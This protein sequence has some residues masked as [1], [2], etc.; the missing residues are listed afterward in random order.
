MCGCS[1]GMVRGVTFRPGYCSRK[2]GIYW[3]V[4]NMVLDRLC[5]W[6]GYEL[7][8]MQVAVGLVVIVTEGLLGSVLPKVATS[9]IVDE[10]KN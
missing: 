8:D 1:L 2:V 10:L 4:F 6:L 7:I 5:V 9:L 3:C